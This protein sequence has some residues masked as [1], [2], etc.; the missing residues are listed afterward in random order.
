MDARF[1]PAWGAIKEGNADRLGELLSTDPEIA[2]ARSDMGHPTLMQALV[3]DGVAL[4]PGVQL[5]MAQQLRLHGALV[6]EPLVSAGSM[7]N[8]VL[9]EYLIAEGGAID[10]K[11]ERMRGWSVLEEALYW[12]NTET[13]RR[14]LELGA[15][16]RN[17]RIAAGVGHLKAVESFFQDGLLRANAGDTNFPFCQQDPDQVSSEPQAVIDNALVYAASGGHADVVRYLL[18][19]GAGIDAIPTG[20]HVR[21]SALHFAA[22]YGRDGMCDLLIEAGAKPSIADL[23]E[24]RRRPPAWARYGGHETLARRLE[25]VA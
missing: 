9:A 10:G 4:E 25:T 14:V 18:D 21:G 8:T 16:I 11:P 2:A 22:M 5:R 23:S 6:D 13:A 3:L 17:L 7:G 24:E 20:F 15:T 1:W 19:R 12:Q